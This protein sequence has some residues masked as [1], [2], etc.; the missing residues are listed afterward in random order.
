MSEDMNKIPMVDTEEI[1]KSNCT[2]DKL[3]AVYFPVYNEGESQS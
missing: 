1:E 2:Q 3:R